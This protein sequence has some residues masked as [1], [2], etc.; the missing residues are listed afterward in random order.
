MPI[1]EFSTNVAEYPIPIMGVNF[2]ANIVTLDP[3]EAI[4]L[5]NLIWRNGLIKRPGSAKFETDEVL[6]GNKIVGLNRFYYGASSK[7]LLVA[8]GT[9]VKYHDGATWQNVKTGLTDGSQTHFT[10]WL[11]NSYIANTDDAPHKWSG[12]ADSAVGA[13]PADTKMFLPYQDRLLSITGGDLIWSG[14]FDDTTWETV[15]NAG[16]RPDTQLFGMIHHSITNADSGFE[17]QVLLSG[18][19]GMYLFSGRDL[20]TPATTGDYTVYSLAT[21]VGCSAVRTMQWTPKGSMWLGN[22]KQV[23]L[24][25]FNSSTPIPV[26]TKIQS[27]RINIEGI[28]KIP[29]GQ[30]ANACAV[31]HDGFYKLSIAQSGKT[32]NNA[33]FWLDITRLHQ[34]D[35]GHWGPW[36]GP[37]LGESIS[38]FAVQ[39]GSG[40]AGE[41][42]AGESDASVGSFVY[43]SGQSDVFGDS[44]ASIDVFY[45]S[46]YNPLTVPYLSKDIH[47]AEVEVLDTTGAITMALHDIS[48]VLKSGIDVPISDSAIYWND[49]FWDE[50]SWSSSQPT[51]L[52]IPISAAIRPRRLSVI[53]EHSNATDRFELYSLFIEAKEQGQPLEAAS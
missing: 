31:Y 17:A 34:D 20:R 19:N 18:A 35:N 28:E 9:T 42:M 15:A 30:L 46:F 12:S 23:Y 36:Y 43:E 32:V 1:P 50:F 11:D 33:Q 44:G 5:K 49:L 8:S 40:D 53:L 21:N 6:T 48:G 3:R 2:Y 37:M 25:P 41:L 4:Y 24:L 29:S 45:Q 16:V 26:G 22:D 10:T 52:Q 47:K 39:N 27:T 14:S 38:V 51:R 7:Q 13:A